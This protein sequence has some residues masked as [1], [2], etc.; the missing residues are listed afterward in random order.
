MEAGG[1]VDQYVTYLRHSE[2][3]NQCCGSGMFIPNQ[4][5]E[6]FPYRIQDPGSA[7]RNLSILAQKWFIS[8]RKYDPG[9]SSR[10][11]IPDPDHDFLPIPDP[12]VKK[13]PDPGFGS[14]TLVTTI[15]YIT[16]LHKCLST[17]RKQPR[18]GGGLKQTQ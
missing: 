6:C 16:D 4:G 1:P 12:G 2:C 15:R 14:A 3:Y 13:A 11:Q 18:K 10:I 7:S 17:P 9:Y 8:S 5:Y